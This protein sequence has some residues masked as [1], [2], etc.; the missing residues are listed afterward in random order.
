MFKECIYCGKTI[1]EVE[2]VSDHRVLHSSHRKCK[3]K[4]IRQ[5]KRG[6]KMW[7]FTYKDAIFILL[8]IGIAL[9]CKH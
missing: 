3:E 4:I 8:F 2:P 1:C 6:I 5:L 9:L 7:D